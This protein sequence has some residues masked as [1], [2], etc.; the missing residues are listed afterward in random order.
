MCI[1]MCR[2]CTTARRWT[3]KNHA[4]RST[5]PSTAPPNPPPN[6]PTNVWARTEAF[7]QLFAIARI[8]TLLA[9]RRTDGTAPAHEARVTLKIAD[10]G[11][12]RHTAAT[13]R[14][15]HVFGLCAAADLRLTAASQC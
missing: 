6:P 3:D 8:V 15:T 13:T 14:S 9:T 10:F 11:F 2:V 4:A 7:A 12:A 1:I 5:K